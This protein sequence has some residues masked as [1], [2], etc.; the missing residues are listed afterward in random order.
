MDFENRLNKAIERGQKARQS[1]QQTQAAH[2]ATED[3]LK[4]MHSAAKLELSE[5]IEVCLKKTGRSLSRLPIF[6][7]RR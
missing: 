7:H 1:H 5:H 4:A 2:A 6:N 3:E